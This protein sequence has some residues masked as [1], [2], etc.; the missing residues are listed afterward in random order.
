MCDCRYLT[1]PPVSIS[2]VPRLCRDYDDRTPLHLAA[3]NGHTAVLEYL[4]KQD[5]VLVNAVD[6][7]GGTPYQDALRHG[8]KGAAALLEEAGCVQGSSDKNSKDVIRQM[9]EQSNAKKEQREKAEREPKIKHVLDNSQESKMVAT[10]SDKLSKEIADQSA[11]IELIS[12]RLIWAL[13]GFCDRL[14]NNSCNIPFTDKTFVKASEHVLRLVSEMRTSVNNSRSTLMQEMQGDESAA[15][16]R[17]WR[18]A[19]K[20]YKLQAKELDDQ[21]RELIMLAKVAKRM[22]KSVIKVCKR[23]GRQ[24][25]YDAA[26]G[27][28]KALLDSTL[29]DSSKLADDEDRRKKA[30]DQ[31]KG[32]QSPMSKSRR[33]WTGIRT[34]VKVFGG[35]SGKRPGNEAGVGVEQSSDHHQQQAAP[36][37]TRALSLFQRGASFANLESPV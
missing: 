18:N 19:S 15:D 2:P 24:S 30:V 29:L 34:T 28:M 6:R 27:N 5:T 10:I 31:V 17:I 25:L 9:I 33:K 13:R 20:E 26:G 37:V 35:F 16:C 14:H 21:M 11:Q 7:F 3:C 8:R 36:K 1:V 22:V 4:L 23:G 12:Q 32:G